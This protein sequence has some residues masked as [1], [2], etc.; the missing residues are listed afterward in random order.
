MAHMQVAGGAPGILGP[1]AV[2]PETTNALRELAGV[3]LPG[4]NLF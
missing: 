3:L 1:M 4:P 2:S